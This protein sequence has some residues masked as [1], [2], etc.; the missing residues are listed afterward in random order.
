MAQHQHTPSSTMHQYQLLTTSTSTTK[1]L[2]SPQQCFN[3]INNQNNQ[4]PR[5]P[6]ARH[7]TA[8]TTDVPDISDNNPFSA[9]ADNP[10]D[11]S[12]DSNLNDTNNNQNVNHY[13]ITCN[14]IQSIPSKKHHF[15]SIQPW[16]NINITHVTLA[17][18]DTKAKIQRIGNVH[19][20][21]GNNHHGLKDVL[22]VPSLSDSLF[23]VKK[24]Q[25][26]QGHYA[27][28]FLQQSNPR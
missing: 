24:H 12:T 3:R 16:T 25:E 15:A 26:E 23:S 8:N 22:Y 18:G 14:N 5:Q 10:P 17:D 6:A 1:A 21:I 13:L 4:A 11:A 27:H 19:L 28:F 9:L 2:C 7:T 20:Q